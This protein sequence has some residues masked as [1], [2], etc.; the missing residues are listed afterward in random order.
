MGFFS[1]MYY[2]LMLLINFQTTTPTLISNPE[3]ESFTYEPNEIDET[4]GDY[5]GTIFLQ[6]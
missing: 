3:S 6:N 1:S 4:C 2:S 5:L